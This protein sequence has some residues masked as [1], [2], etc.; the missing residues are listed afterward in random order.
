MDFQWC[1]SNFHIY[2][3]PFVDTPHPLKKNFVSCYLLTFYLYSFCCRFCGD[4]IYG[5]S[6]LCLPTYTNVGTANGGTLPL[7]IF[8]AHV[9]MLSCSFL[10]FDPKA[11]PSS[12]LFLLLKALLKDSTTTFL[13]FSNAAYISSL[14]LLTLAYG[15]YRFS[16]WWTNNTIRKRD[17]SKCSTCLKCPHRLKGIV[18][19]TK[20]LGHERHKLLLIE[21]FDQTNLFNHVTNQTFG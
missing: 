2:P 9:F 5:T 3:H 16:F 19:L 13:L 15:F 20:G 14:I 18:I 4:D 6:A 17:F 10:T 21:T 7:I 11:P 8:W 12:A 1:P